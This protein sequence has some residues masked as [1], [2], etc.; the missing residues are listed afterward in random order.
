ME[1]QSEVLQNEAIDGDVSL[2]AQRG[3]PEAQRGVPS[4]DDDRDDFIDGTEYELR[5]SEL[6]SINEALEANEVRLMEE[7]RLV[8]KEKEELLANLCML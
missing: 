5:V 4:E 2:E 8:E 6:D 1:G 7:D 3:V